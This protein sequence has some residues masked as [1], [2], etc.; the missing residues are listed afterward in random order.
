M[1]KKSNLVWKGMWVA[2]ALEI[3]KHRNRIVFAMAQLH[4]FWAKLGKLR[5]QCSFPD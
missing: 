1:S 5:I 3:W 2:S 4:G